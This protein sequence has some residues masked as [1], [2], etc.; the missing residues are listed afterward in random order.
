[1]ATE[2]R[3]TLGLAYFYNSSGELLALQ[4]KN[5]RRMAALTMAILNSPPAGFTDILDFSIALETALNF[6]G[7]SKEELLKVTSMLSSLEPG[8]KSDWVKH[9]FKKDQLL[10]RGY[11]GYGFNFNGLY[12]EMAYL[13]AAQGEVEKSLRSIDTLLKYNEPYYQRDY[14]NLLD[15]ASN[16]AS[17]YY[18]SGHVENLDA[19][20]AGY[21]ERKKI[22]ELEFYQRLLGRSQPYQLTR[23]SLYSNFWNESSN[24]N[25][26]YNEPGEIAFFFEK[27]REV[28]SRLTNPD[29]KN[30]QLA[31]AY[32]HQGITLAHKSE[33]VKDNFDTLKV[34]D[35]FAK[36]IAHYQKVSKKYLAEIIERV[37]TGADVT[38]STR[39]ALYLLP[40]VNTQFSPLGSRDFHWNFMST[41][42]MEYLIDQGL[43][44]ALYEDPKDLKL[45]ESWLT[46]YHYHAMAGDIFMRHHAAF[47]SLEK[48]A[49][50]FQ[51]RNL[52]DKMDLNLL[53]LY[54]GYYACQQDDQ[55]LALKY[56][57]S[58]KPENFNN[59]LQYKILTGYTTSNSFKLMASAFTCFSENNQ[60]AEAKK[61]LD[62]FK[63]PAN[64]SSMYAFAAR[65]F[66]EKKKD[67]LII[68]LFL[69]SAIVEMGRTENLNSDQ[70]NRFRVAV[71][72][73]TQSP[74]DQSIGQAQNIIKNQTLKFIVL[75]RM[76]RGIAY[77]QE[78][79][80]ASNMIPDNISDNDIMEFLRNILIGYAES[81][82][83]RGE[84]QEYQ[85]SGFWFD[86]T[87]YTP[88]VNESN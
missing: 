72:L 81:Q 10:L 80:K 76:A 71:T 17:V 61:I 3:S 46:D 88:Y 32:K 69:D 79:Y 5:G 44:D 43:F 77:N 31:I 30:F 74:T 54:L 21:C 41:C 4:Q 59:L 87:E 83:V 14:T 58:V 18:R 51:K 15:N 27:F 12:Q 34:K 48:I 75:Q 28:A 9:N 39:N 53:Y 67:P 63:K 37:G 22:T 7:F 2:W 64:R 36:S 84:W 55:S 26:Q 78:L 52:Q 82:T 24:V 60:Q 73:V 25:L 19:F 50:A 62:F 86:R 29:E 20:V 66:V 65:E 16:I 40:D 68:Q 85:D 38:A 1:T 11:Q 49:A 57:T 23:N 8:D 45:I 42:F 6:N 35:L 13:Y 47:S 70:P 56:Y 33:V